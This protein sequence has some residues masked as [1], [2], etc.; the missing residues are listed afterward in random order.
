MVKTKAIY[1]KEA[2]DKKIQ[3]KEDVKALTLLSDSPEKFEKLIDITTRYEKYLSKLN[4]TLNINLVPSAVSLT[5]EYWKAKY[6][7]YKKKFKSKSTKTK[8]VN[9]NYYNIMLCWTIK[10]GYCLCE[11]IID[12]LR[13]YFK[14]IEI[15]AVDLTK[16]DFPDRV[17]FCETYKLICNKEQYDIVINSAEY[18]LNILSDSTYENCNIGIFGKS[19]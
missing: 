2:K 9:S 5:S 6:K 8:I 4:K 7:E 16:T 3:V 17:E 18:L 19:Y 13:N 15:P 10:H 1:I 11:G 12:K 14:S